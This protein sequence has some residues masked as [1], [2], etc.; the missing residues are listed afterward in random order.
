MT[1]QQKRT[2]AECIAIYKQALVGKNFSPQTIKAYMSDLKQF[3]EWLKTRRVDWD[4]PY[5]IERINIVEFI[6][7]LAAQK[8]SAQTRKRKLA[9]I[10]GFLK[11]LK[12]NQI[13]FGNP[14]DTIVGPIREEREPAI[15]LKTE[16]KA[17]LQV[18]GANPR[19][20]A[21]IMLFLQTGLRVSCSCWMNS[22]RKR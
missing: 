6:N 8:A 9:T 11:F 20:F 2:T 15:L 12:D 19:D 16:Y 5:R 17:L 7:F 1:P 21:I 13:I 14:A 4:A 18:A 3:F 22:P 10:R